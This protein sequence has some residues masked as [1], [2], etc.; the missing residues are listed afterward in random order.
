MGFISSYHETVIVLYSMGIT[1]F[2]CTLL[3]L[4]ACQTKVKKTSIN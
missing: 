1:A 4:F 3:S 2:I